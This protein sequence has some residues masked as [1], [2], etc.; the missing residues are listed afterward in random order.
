MVYVNEPKT[1]RRDEAALNNMNVEALRSTV[2][3][4][5]N[6]LNAIRDGVLIA[7][8][9]QPDN[10][11]SYVNAAF[12]R[13][14][15]YAAADITGKN[16]R[17]LQGPDTEFEAMETIRKSIAAR[18][19]CSVTILNYR[20]DGDSFWNDLRI[21]P[22]FN[23][24]D[25]LTHYVAALNDVSDRV[26]ALHILRKSEAE[27]R[28]L[29]AS[30]DCGFCVVQL[31]YDDK[32]RAV[33]WLYLETNQHFE[34]LSG[35][36]NVRGKRVK[37]VLPEVESHWL[38]RLARISA[39]GTAERFTEASPAL[40]R[41]FDVHGFRFGEA[42][43]NCV[44][45]TFSNITERKKKEKRILAARDAAE[46]ACTEAEAASHAKSNFLAN[47]S[48]DIRTPLTAI[49]G[50]AEILDQ[51]LCEPD[52]LQATAIIRQNV[53]YLE[54]LLGDVLDLAKIEAGKLSVTMERLHLPDLVDDV[55]SL[56]HARAVAEGIRL[57]VV[58]DGPVP[59]YIMSDRVRVRQ[60]L[61]NLLSNAIKFTRTQ[62]SRTYDVGIHVSF[63]PTVSRTVRIDIV[64]FGIGISEQE[65]LTLFD[66]FTQVD[67][68]EGY[69]QSGTGLGLSIC[70]R[71][72]S[73]LEGKLTLQSILGKGSTF[74]LSLPVSGA[75]SVSC[76]RPNAHRQFESVSEGV[77]QSLQA[78]VLVVD[79]RADIRSF[80]QSHL[81]SAGAEVVSVDNGQSAIDRI[82]GQGKYHKASADEKHYDVVLLDMQ[83]P[84]KDGFQT[85]IALRSAGFSNPIIAL[86]ASVLPHDQQRC[87]DVGCSAF[88]AKPIRR[89][90]LIRE[91]SSFVECAEDDQ[92]Q[93]V[94]TQI[95]GQDSDI[96]PSSSY[97]SQAKPESIDDV[98]EACQQVVLFV[99]DDLDSSKAV[100]RIIESD[101][102]TV[103]LARGVQEAVALAASHYPQVIL[104]DLSL[105]DGLG[106]DVVR[107]V[108]SLSDKPNPAAI[109]LSG[110]LLEDQQGLFAAN[111]LK[112]V[113]RRVLLNALNTVVKEV[114]S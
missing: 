64:D 94:N 110:T 81:E 8:A 71:L 78:R 91:V 99:E 66:P 73:L 79:D 37:Q 95:V 24:D 83:M 90:C 42:N 89:N 47:M 63:D 87:L 60:V 75:D 32:G 21:A 61:I 85:T 112:P 4:Q 17:F 98:D 35:L 28:D 105:P 108:F 13:M 101:G 93:S 70:R 106:I 114:A 41:W 11:V 38:N 18:N 1:G 48:H 104:T 10:P 7:D 26:R 57:N 45:M 54:S 3:W 103:M 111:L 46:R 29:F 36:K 9:R 19:S 27:A 14:T 113:S 44:A 86:T 59:E 12:E 68:Q 22:M 88:L 65:Q 34:A 80:L 31:I 76:I 55:L 58:Y 5:S 30:M 33:D 2:Q 62:P 72:A 107:Q 6:A 56:M 15:G 50:F 92:S 40:D 20:K 52:D 51:T 43:A 16:C 102:W 82:T 77:I 53:D 69:Q 49:L 97:R 84:G 74:S 109:A 23:D 25:E 96:Y 39:T 67:T 100:K